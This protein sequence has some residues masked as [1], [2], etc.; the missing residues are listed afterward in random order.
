MIMRTI[1]NVALAGLMFASV[2]CVRA[3]AGFDAFGAMRT[4]SWPPVVISALTS[5]APVDLMLFVGTVNL[6]ISGT[7]NA[8]TGT[9]TATIETSPDLT[10]WTG[11]ASVAL[12][13]QTTIIYTNSYYASASM[14][15]TNTYLLPG[16]IVTPSVASAGFA[17][18]YLNQTPFTNS[19]GA[20]NL[21]TNGIYSIGFKV[22][23][24]PKYLHILWNT[25]ASCTVAASLTGRQIYPTPQVV[26]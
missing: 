2:L 19:P 3:Q 13:T 5:N 22:D 14:K 17:T 6:I 16:T 26:Q 25:A 10:N 11:I 12:A 24:Q 21:L 20:I 9:L 1:R 4:A 15:A 18:S 7:T 8:N 23:D